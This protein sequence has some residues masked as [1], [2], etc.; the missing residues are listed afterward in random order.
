MSYTVDSNEKSITKI[1]E[2]SPNTWKQKNINNPLGKEKNLKKNKKIHWTKLNWNIIY[3]N[4]CNPGISGKF[5]PL[6]AYKRKGEKSQIDILSFHL[7]N[8]GGKN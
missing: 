4:L 7:K 6:N 2:K 1:T 5:I 8:L 3:Q